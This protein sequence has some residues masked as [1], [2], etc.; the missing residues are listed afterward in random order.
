MRRL[1]LAS[2][3]AVS[4]LSLGACSGSSGESATSG[5][6]A[7]AE[8]DKIVTIGVL[9]PLDGGLTDAH[10]H[11]GRPAKVTAVNGSEISLEAVTPRGTESYSVTIGAATKISIVSAA[12]TADLAAGA[13][14]VVD[15]GPNATAA[16][17][18]LIVK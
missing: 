2:A 15:F 11:L 3:L 18:V 6:S 13:S 12:T 1:F 8:G 5:S 16:K 10:V 9:A 17:S 4:L 7:K 14:V